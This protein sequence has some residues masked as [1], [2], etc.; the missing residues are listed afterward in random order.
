LAW[1]AAALLPL[2]LAAPAQ[3]IPNTWVASNG[4]GT[5]CTR[6]GPCADFQTALNVTDNGGVINCVDSGTF[7]TGVFIDN[8]SVT[9][10]CTG[11]FAAVRTNSSAAAVT[12]LNGTVV[13]RGLSILGPGSV[14]GVDVVGGTVHIEQCRIAGFQNVLGGYGIWFRPTNAMAR[15]YVSDTLIETNGA[16][17]GSGGILVS[18]RGAA[19]ARTLIERTQIKNNRDGIIVRNTESTNAMSM[20]IVQIR[21]T[22]VADGLGDGISAVT[23]AGKGVVSI[24]ADRTSLLLNNWRGVMAQG[25][26]SY[27]ILTSST[28][29]SNQIGLQADGGQIFSYQNNQLTGNGSDGAPTVVLTTK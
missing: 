28:V 15:L 1:L 3:A 7:A 25:P 9:I 19:I 24:T 8:K 21:D 10:D 26:L 29:M 22:I 16:D 17:P 13:L 2:A 12:V 27:V 6:A 18:P 23:A 5:N 14:A 11:H 20:A 4:V